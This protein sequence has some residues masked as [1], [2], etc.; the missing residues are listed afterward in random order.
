MIVPLYKTQYQVIPKIKNGNVIV[1]G[2]GVGKS[3]TSL[4]YYC[5]KNGGML[6]DCGIN[7]SNFLKR[8]EKKKLIVI[9]IAKKR[10]DMDWEKEALPFG[11]V[12]ELIVD[13][14]NNIK[15]YKDFENCFFIFDEQKTVTYGTWS[16]TFI[17]ICKK[18]EWI[19]LSATPGDKWI[20][21]MAIF[22]A[23]GI[24]KNQTHFEYE[25]VVFD[26]M[27]KYKNILRYINT[28]VLEKHRNKIFIFMKAS[29][30]RTK[31]KKYIE[32]DYD[33][34][35]YNLVNE[36]RWNIFKEKPIKDAG[37]LCYTS[38]K[39]V[40]MSK[41]K[42]YIIDKIIKEKKKV[43]IFYNYNYEL[44]ILEQFL[45]DNKIKYSQYNGIKHEKIPTGESWAYLVNYSAGAEAW[46]CIDTNTII[47]YSLN[48]A[49]RV[50]KQSAGRID[51]SNSPYMEL[52]YYYLITNS[53]I[54][55]AILK[56]LKN[57]K[58]FNELSFSKT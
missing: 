33:M 18:N 8:K 25:H 19:M 36:K 51:R 42:L 17:K 56:A 54:D 15:K 27:S 1:G 35:S 22:I 48:Y 14:W 39:V 37:E 11:I 38:R 9:T 34:I 45:N 4:A 30:E 58:K 16:K 43:I 2:T 24:Y 23:N 31:Y 50:M 53:K 26:R 10:N 3:R 57:K 21:Y 7:I 49:Y 32:H 20:D 41:T 29:S 44:E 12:G 47:F 52:H 6:E 5:Y 13:S 40:N 55:K 46:N 28:D